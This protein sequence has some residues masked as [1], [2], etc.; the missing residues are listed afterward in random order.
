MGQGG[1]LNLANVTN[2]AMVRS[3]Q[4]SYQMNSWD[5][6]NKIAALD[7]KQSY[8]EWNQGAFKLTVDDAAEARYAIDSTDLFE[9]QARW[10]HLQVQCKTSNPNYVIG[11][12]PNHSFF[13]GWPN[14]ASLKQGAV[15]EF[16]WN[17]DG[18]MSVALVDLSLIFDG[19]TLSQYAQAVANN[20]LTDEQKKTLVALTRLVTN[21]TSTNWDY[22][23]VAMEYAKLDPSKVSTVQVGQSQDVTLPDGVKATY[24]FS[25]QMQR[26]DTFSW[27]FKETLA[28]GYKDTLKVGIPGV[29]DV[30]SEISVNMSFE[31]NQST[32][33]TKQATYSVTNTVE[34]QGPGQ[35]LI[36]GY[37]DYVNDLPIPFTARCH[38]TAKAGN[39]QL[40]A[41]VVRALLQ[42]TK[43]SPGF[44]GRIAQDNV[45]ATT[46]EVT[47]TG[48]LVGT[49]GVK[50]RLDALCV[51]N[52]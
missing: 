10:Q 35:F 31:A 19:A 28:V 45:D 48:T 46:V 7:W 1:K 52:R 2:K 11:T 4:H 25:R 32:T 12:I 6:P 23:L 26:T 44:T 5:L 17:H 15:Y 34:L 43:Y 27:G 41:S 38:V 36:Q 47:L 14:W 13:D 8:V 51:Y 18:D 16:G 9:V 20:Q 50:G 29:G 24:A 22:L 30:S 40:P 21:N 3:G 42:N 49:F 39:Y 37:L 33:A